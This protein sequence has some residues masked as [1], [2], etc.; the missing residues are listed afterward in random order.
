MELH[1]L[2]QLLLV[3]VAVV[4]QA[5]ELVALEELQHLLVQQVLLV[6]LQDKAHT[7]ALAQLLV[8]VQ[9]M[10]QW[11]LLVQPMELELVLVDKWLLQL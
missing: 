10:A 7:V 9:T 1:T 8:I 2:T 6:A 4:D 3:A 11:V 5:K